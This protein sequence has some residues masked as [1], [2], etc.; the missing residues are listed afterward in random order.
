MA[1]LIK[2]VYDY[3]WTSLFVGIFIHSVVSTI[4]TTI[5]KLI[6]KTLNRN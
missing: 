2:T 4:C 6:D 3:P 5:N 1:E